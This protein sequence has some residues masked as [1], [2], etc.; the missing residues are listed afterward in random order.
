MKILGFAGS[1]SSKSINKKLVS[2]TLDQISDSSLETELIDLN[3]YKLPMFNVDV[4]EKD[5]YPDNAYKF[6]EKLNEADALIV[7]MAEH[8]NSYAAEVKNLLDWCS[9][10]ELGFF[11][12]KPMLLMSTSP[13]GYGGGN[14]LEA[15]KQRFP[16]FKADIIRTFKLPSFNDNFS[17]DHGITDE[18]NRSEHSKALNQF[19]DHLSK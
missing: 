4:E 3:D 13:G 8:N 9:R 12:E 6:L 2:F 11:G 14:V 17:E 10:I 18:E 1:T 5:G 19:L 15:S 16:K 7:S